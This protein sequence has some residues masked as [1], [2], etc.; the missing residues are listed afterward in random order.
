MKNEKIIEVNLGVGTDQ[1]FPEIIKI[2]IEDDSANKEKKNSLK[3]KKT[4]EE[5]LK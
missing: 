2:L 3:S 5:K 1:L 4:K